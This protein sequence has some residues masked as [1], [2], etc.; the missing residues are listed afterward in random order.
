MLC[1]VFVLVIISILVVIGICCCCPNIF[2]FAAKK[3]DGKKERGQYEYGSGGIQYAD[4]A[5]VKLIATVDN[6]AE[7]DLPVT[8]PWLTVSEVEETDFI[9]QGAGLVTNST[10]PAPSVQGLSPTAG[11]SDLQL[12]HNHFVLSDPLEPAHLPPKRKANSNSNAIQKAATYFRNGIKRILPATESSYA[13]QERQLEHSIFSDSNS[14]T[15]SQ[16]QSSE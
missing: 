11:D 13:I 12:L 5:T 3:R 7:R 8:D 4:M 6:S 1:F 10:P 2:V 16:L 15:L 9:V 14:V